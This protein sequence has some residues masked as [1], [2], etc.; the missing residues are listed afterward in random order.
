LVVIVVVVIVVVIVVSFALSLLS[1]YQVVYRH[2]E[3][4]RVL[5]KANEILQFPKKTGQA[6]PPSG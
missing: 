2:P 5:P 6:V 4:R 1:S 3:A